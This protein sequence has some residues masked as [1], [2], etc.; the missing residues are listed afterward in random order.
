MAT[1]RLTIA[2]FF[3]S[4][5]VPT[6]MVTDSTVGIATGIAATVS[7]RANCNVVED[8][9]PAEDRDG[10]DK[11]HQGHGED[12]QIIAD[13]QHRTLE[14]A[15]GVGLLHQ[16]RGLAEVGVR[17]VAYTIASISPWRIIDPENTASP[18]LRLAG[19]IRPSAR[20]DRL[21]RIARQQARVG[22]H[23]VA[24]PQTDDIARN[25]FRCLRVNPFPI[26]FHLGI[27]R[28][29]GFQSSDGVAR[30]VFFPEA[31]NGVGT[32]QQRG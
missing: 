4:R 8:R 14:V 20:T 27:D 5:R 26:A 18:G 9:V 2:S 22:R 28:Q 12:D 19:K 13:L 6:A 10:D 23:N 31:D 17:P 24:Q 1:S 30:L 25:Q 7:T 16:L 11:R 29:F 21:P 32:Q 15:D 3:A